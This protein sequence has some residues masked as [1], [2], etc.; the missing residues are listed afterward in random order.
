MTSR[1]KE[2]RIEGKRKKKENK[3][4]KRERQKEGKIKNK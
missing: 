1:R 4:G 2:G 3:A